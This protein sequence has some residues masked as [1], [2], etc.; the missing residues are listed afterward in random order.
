MTLWFNGSYTVDN[1]GNR[2]VSRAAAAAGHTDA[3]SIEEEDNDDNDEMSIAVNVNGLYSSI[4]NFLCVPT[5]IS[6][7]WQWIKL[8]QQVFFLVSGPPYVQ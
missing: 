4:T 5:I 1:T 8:L 2:Q 6:V 3:D 7:G